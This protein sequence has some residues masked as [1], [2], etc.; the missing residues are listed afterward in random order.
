MDVIILQRLLAA[1]HGPGRSV[2]RVLG[3]TD[4]RLVHL[5]Q[6]AILPP[7]AGAMG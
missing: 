2:E 7:R 4:F 1:G 3:T 6:V 5:L